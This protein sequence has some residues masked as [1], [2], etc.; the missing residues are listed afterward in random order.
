[1]IR[2]PASLDLGPTPDAVVSV[3]DDDPSVLRSL[4][5]LLTA[6]GLDV[7]TYSSATAFL[8]SPRRACAGC[9]VL[10]VRLPDLNGLE[11]QRV[12]AARDQELPVVFITGHGDIP[13]SVRAMKAGAIDF[14]TKPFTEQALLEAITVALQES[15]ARMAAG[16]EAAEITQRFS[17]LSGREVEVMREVVAGRLNKQIAADLG[18]A[19]RTVKLHRARISAKLGVRAVADLVRLAERAGI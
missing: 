1:M 5:R 10:D 17:S 14:L 8:A 7:E 9:L 4:R 3:V 6:H 2:P 15:R 11:L 16:Q 12:L 18:I 19:V 13:M